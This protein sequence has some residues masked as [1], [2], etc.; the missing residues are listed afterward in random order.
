[1]NSKV[2][3]DKFEQQM[4]SRLKDIFPYCQTCRY[5]GKLFLDNQKVDLSG[6]PG[7]YFQCKHQERTQPYHEILKEM[8]DTN[9]T[10]VILHK[11]NNSGVVVVME[12]DDFL[13]LIKKAR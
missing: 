5:V 10:N 12:L 11:R 4:V 8:P 6:T 9:N 1:M 13:Q 2:K 7:Y 3:G